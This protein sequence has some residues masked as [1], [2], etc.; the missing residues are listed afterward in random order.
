MTNI[1]CQFTSDKLLPTLDVN[2][3]RDLT[4]DVGQSAT[5]DL[6]LDVGHSLSLV[7]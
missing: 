1:V 7:T 5:R 4:H 3:T 6:T 2:V